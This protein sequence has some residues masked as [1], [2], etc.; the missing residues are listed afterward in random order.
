MKKFFM[1]TGLGILPLCAAQ[2]AWA[3]TQGT[4][5]PTST[6]TIN[7]FNLDA[8]DLGTFD[9]ALTQAQGTDTFCVYDNGAAFSQTYSIT[10]TSGNNP[11]NYQLASGANTI[12]YGLEYDDSQT[13]ANYRGVASGVPL[14]GN[15]NGSS[16]A[17]NC[18]SVGGDNGQVRI[19]VLNT[20]AQ[21]S[22]S[23]TYTDTL[24]VL[25]EPEP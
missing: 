4:L 14:T 8:I 21:G 25:V 6:M 5:A 3:V 13:G 23:G 24:S 22:P 19:T 18:S 2:L 16:G 10:F 15:V 9:F 12:D 7:V 11:G 20:Q 1:V 17:S